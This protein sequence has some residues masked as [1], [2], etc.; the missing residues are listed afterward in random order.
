LECRNLI[1]WASTQYTKHEDV[2][3]LRFFP[4]PSVY[5]EK[6]LT[7]SYRIQ[8]RQQECRRKGQPL[9][10]FQPRNLY[11]ENM[12]FKTVPKQY[13]NFDYSSSEVF[14]ISG[15]EKSETQKQIENNE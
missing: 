6:N 10:K 1:D 9:E 13:Y 12:P 5:G 3:L 2:K 4:S 14:Q 11:A 7:D 15:T 8:Q